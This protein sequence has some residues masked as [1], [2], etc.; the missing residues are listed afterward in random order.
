MTFSLMIYATKHTQEYFYVP[1]IKVGREDDW[2][3][4]N[5]LLD[6]PVVCRLEPVLD[7]RPE[8]GLHVRA[9]LEV[10]PDQLNG[11]LLH[12]DPVRA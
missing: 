6:Y 3:R 7:E 1:G 8:H 4:Q 9:E 5:G 11:G 10:H 12:P 2:N